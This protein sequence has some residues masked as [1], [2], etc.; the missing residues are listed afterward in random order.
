MEVQQLQTI[1]RPIRSLPYCGSK[2]RLVLAA[3]LFFV[4]LLAVATFSNAAK[5]EITNVSPTPASINVPSVAGSTFSVSW[6]VV[7]HDHLAGGNVTIN[8]PSATLQVNGQTIATLG[9]TLSQT[10]TTPPDQT[11]TFTETMTITPAISRQ[12][13]KARAGTVKI[14]RTFNDG[15]A[16]TGTGSV[17]LFSTA[18]NA[19]ALAVRRIDLSFE[20]QSRTDVVQKGGPLRAVADVSFASN[21]LLRG[22][23]RLVDPT[24]SLGSGRGRVLQ[25]VRQQ[26]VSSGQGRVRILSPKLP[27]DL[28]GLYLL[29]F[30]VEDTTASINTPI[31][32]YF[33]IDGSGEGNV[34]KMTQLS[35]T[36]GAS[37][38][39]DTVFSWQ[40][41]ADAKA[42]EVQIF[43]LGQDTPV[44]AK[45]VPSQNT[46]LTLSALS[47][48][49]LVSGK[50]YEWRVQ[51][52][53]TN[54][55]IAASERRKIIMP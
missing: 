3:R 5:A 6:R 24:A 30:S 7:W 50:S 26:L 53:S 9:S 47:F 55:I 31:L 21:G 36:T 14:V 18:E 52:I 16:L 51:A 20:N 41:V 39:N 45:I 28:N 43:E 33:V 11:L 23:W 13:L 4:L 44:T 49:D 15:S 32:R 27:T 48:E 12:L 1:T 8:S 2:L 19:G 38:F 54:Q 37:V 22:E 35:P 25:V 29:S 40:A 46:K 34:M 42:Y 10:T 17:T